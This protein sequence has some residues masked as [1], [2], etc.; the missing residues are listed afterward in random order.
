MPE[1]S[2]APAL[3]LRPPTV[4]DE[5]VCRRYHEQLN[6]E[7]FSFLLADGTWDE[8]LAQVER[9]AAGTDLPSGRVR[10]DF[11]LGEVDDAVV[12]RVSI[13]H[14]LNEGL[15]RF[16]GHV[17]YAVAPEHRRRG[18]AT[19]M[20]TQAVARLAAEG[21]SPVL[22]TCDAGNAASEATILACGGERDADDVLPDG[23]VK[24]RFWIRP[25]ARTAPA[26]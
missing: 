7:G 23:R 24:H 4:D 16:G 1:L 26:S 13:R 18:Y 22:V 14:D 9:E 19:Q 3:T 17:G 11:L 15:R 10:A 5:A 12:G 8:L 21:V 25:S 6:A 2:P 20:L